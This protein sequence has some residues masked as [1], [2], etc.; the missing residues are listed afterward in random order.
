MVFIAFKV[1]IIVI[2]WIFFISLLVI[3]AITKLIKREGKGG[4][5][6]QSL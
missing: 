4:I 6:L 5:F 2:I 1:Y 3:L